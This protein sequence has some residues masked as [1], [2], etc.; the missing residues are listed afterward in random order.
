MIAGRIYALGF[1]VFHLMFWRIFKWKE[2]LESLNPINR[3]VMQIMNLCLIIVFIT[4]A[5]VVF[6]FDAE[7][8][9]TVT[10]R[11][12]LVCFAVFWFMRAAMQVY[13]FGL[14]KPVSVILTIVFLFGGAVFLVPVV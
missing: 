4:M 5:A 2:D 9:G 11:I 12:I 6:S 3:A 14:Q 1:A 13:F 8:L 7:T 10:G